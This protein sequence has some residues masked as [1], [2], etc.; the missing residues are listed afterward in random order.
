[1]KQLAISFVTAFLKVLYILAHRLLGTKNQIVCLSRQSNEIPIDFKL[2]KQ[3]IE[4]DRPGYSVVIYAKKLSNPLAYAFHMMKQTVCIAQSQAVVLDSYC[5]VVG[6]LRETIQAPVIQMWHAMGNMKKFG[7]KTLDLPEGRSSNIAHLMHM[8]EGYDSV[9]ISSKSFIDDYVAGFHVSPK[10]VYECPLPK[11]DLLTSASYREARRKEILSRYPQLSKKANIVY[12]PTFRKPSTARD[13][14]ALHDL[15]N[16]V[17]FNRYNLIYKPH[18][19][20][21]LRFENE[22]VFQEYDQTCDMLYVADYVISDYSTVI[23][24]AGLMGIPVYLYIYDWDSYKKRRGL[25]LDFERDVPAPKAKTAE[26]LVTE[27]ESDSFSASAYAR[28][29]H[30]NIAVPINGSCTE[31][32]S[33]HIFQ[34]I[35]TC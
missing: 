9:V 30:H 13:Q 24:E 7:Y 2:L 19:V 32:L 16:A 14:K 21:S 25:N 4:K 28:F 34:L 12:C 6:L 5:I 17:D 3:Q 11:T 31:S 15:A 23:Y 10:I 29:I 1:M 20:S 8:H 26:S 35:E 27:I 18:P 22:N 33:N